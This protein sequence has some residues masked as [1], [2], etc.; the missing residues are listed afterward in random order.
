MFSKKYRAIFICFGPSL[1]R[2]NNKIYKALYFVKSTCKELA[3]AWHPRM[4]GCGWRWN[5]NF[6]TVLLP[7]KYSALGIF[8][9]MY[10]AK[11]VLVF[12]LILIKKRIQVQDFSVHVLQR[13][14]Y[15]VGESFMYNMRH[16]IM[17]PTHSF[18]FYWF[19]KRVWLLLCLLL[20]FR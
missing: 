2:C 20:S 8:V 7:H 9:F 12:L 11:Y 19:L 14:K 17:L 6:E 1:K 5:H 15:F 18:P 10:R 4:S 16:N 13:N 3:R